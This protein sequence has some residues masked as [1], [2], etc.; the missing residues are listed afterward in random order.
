MKGPERLSVRTGPAQRLLSAAQLD[1]PSAAA[2]RRALAFT[3]A[4]ASLAATGAAAA[5]GTG[6]LAKSVVLS[7]C[8][9]TLGG[10]V[11]AFTASELSSR[12]GGTEAKPTSSVLIS[13]SGKP[14]LGAARRPPA[15]VELEPPAPEPAAPRVEPPDAL[16][17]SQRFAEQ[18]S[19]IGAPSQSPPSSA[20]Q[21]A[22]TLPAPT[23][24]SLLEE[25]RMVEAA[26]TAIAK[27]DP[28]LALRA[29]DGY[30]QAY[31]RGQFR[32]ESLA[33]RVQALS[34]RGE[35]TRARALAAEFRK[36]YPRHPLL[37][38]VAAAA[39]EPP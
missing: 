36:R 16:Q 3:S 34:Q 31:P 13:S 24:P 14:G 2:R 7:V 4:A 27:R 21:L 5:A 12:H 18:R 11:L 29:L 30:E 33:L 10:G 26:R 17:H 37:R 25:L 39:G 15:S 32:P 20:S 35:T 9:G 23:E 38:Q 22:L 6:A 1:Q 8:L 19:S 28:L